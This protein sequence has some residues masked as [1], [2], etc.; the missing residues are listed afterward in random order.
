[1]PVLH[2]A[3]VGSGASPGE[4]LAGAAQTD[5]PT[6]TAGDSKASRAQ[7]YSTESGRHPGT[8]LTDAAARE[9]PTPTAQTYGT[10]RGGSAG[11][12]EP[13]RPSLEGAA[14]DWPTP[15]SHDAKGRGLDKGGRNSDNLNCQVAAKGALLNPRWV[16][17][18]QGWPLGLTDLTK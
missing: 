5:W 9:W 12:V 7:G 15:T 11:R 8:T 3:G 1:M 14:R 6:P 18:L 17:A 2:T 10:N 4:G 13:V 16:A